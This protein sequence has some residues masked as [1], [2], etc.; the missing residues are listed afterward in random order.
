MAPAPHTHDPAADRRPLKLRDV[1]PWDVVAR[2]C[3]RVGL[4]PNAI[5]M[6][7]LFAGIASGAALAATSMV[8]TDLGQ[9]LWFLAAVVLVFGRGACNILDGVV[10]VNAN[11]ASPIGLLYNE[12]PD[13][14]ADA[15]VMIGAGYAVGGTALLGWAAAVVAVFVAYIRV[16]A[17][18]AGAPTD[19][20][21]PMAKPARLVVLLLAA[22]YTA[23]TPIDWRPAWGP[24]GGWG[25]IDVALAVIIALGLLT[26]G[27]RLH[28]ASVALGAGRT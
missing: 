9:R 28:R 1:L 25:A 15:A 5:S 26:A 16:Q 17:V 8:E 7:G 10:A 2:G 21:G 19:Y 20:A 13:R 18:V 14:V 27:R 24:G 12:V 6:I 23:V 22:I 3:V 11:K 4:S